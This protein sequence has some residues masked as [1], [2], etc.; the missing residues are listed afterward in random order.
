MSVK[1]ICV[2]SWLPCEYAFPLL[3]HVYVHVDSWFVKWNLNIPVSSITLF[4]YTLMLMLISCSV[5]QEA[6]H[7][8]GGGHN[9]LSGHTC[10]EKK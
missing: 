6:L 9:N 7:N 1:G 8:W 3:N 4:L 2:A 5:A 10:M